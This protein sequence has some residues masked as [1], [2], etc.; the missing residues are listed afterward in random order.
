MRFFYIDDDEFNTITV[1]L[2]EFLETH[3][4]I[5]ERRSGVAPKDEGD[6]AFA[7]EVG[8][9]NLDVTFRI[10]QF[11]IRGEVADLGRFGVQSKL[12]REFFI[13]PLHR[14]DK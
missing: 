7:S 10:L 8:E 13:A 1:L 9:S 3:G 6:R 14:V 4:P 5:T 11:E 12:P 2:I